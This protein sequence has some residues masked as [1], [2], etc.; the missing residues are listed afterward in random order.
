MA[1]VAIAL[2]VLSAYGSIKEGQDKKK[3]YDQQAAM[4]RIGAANVG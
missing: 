1:A 2:T 4:T 3:Y